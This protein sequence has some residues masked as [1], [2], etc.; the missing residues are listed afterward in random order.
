[1]YDANAIV[2]RARG[3]PAARLRPAGGGCR[4][5]QRFANYLNRKLTLGGESRLRGYP[6]GAWGENV[7]ACNLELRSRPAEYGTVQLGAT[8][9]LDAGAGLIEARARTCAI[10]SAPACGWYSRSSSCMRVDWALPLELDA[11]VSRVTSIFPGRFV[12][13]LKQ[14]FPLPTVDPPFVN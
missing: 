6:S 3:Q 5:A 9:F 4:V 14:A 13:T 7:L 8:A 10:Q 11:K 2:S 1:M 12:V